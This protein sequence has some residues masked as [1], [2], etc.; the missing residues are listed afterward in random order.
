MQVLFSIDDG[1]VRY[2]NRG[3]VTKNAET[4]TNINNKTDIL[5]TNST[6]YSPYISR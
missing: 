1:I 3:I 4:R 2:E 5:G 6:I